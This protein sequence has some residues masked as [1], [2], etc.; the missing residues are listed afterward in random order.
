MLGCWGRA[1]W[2]QR[3]GVSPQDTHLT[4]GRL[5]S[6]CLCECVPCTG[7]GDARKRKAT[8]S[9]GAAASRSFGE[10]RKADE[11]GSVPGCST[12]VDV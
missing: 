4:S 7:R 2:G 6:W 1:L 9:L 3:T 8:F 5:L 11:E 12:D 10:S